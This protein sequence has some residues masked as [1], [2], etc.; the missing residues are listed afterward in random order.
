M[1]PE[2]QPEMMNATRASKEF[3]L[4]RWAALRLASRE[5]HAAALMPRGVTQERQDQPLGDDPGRGCFFRLPQDDSGN[6]R[7]KTERSRRVQLA[8]LASG[9][10]EQ[11]LRT[12]VAIR[13]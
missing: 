8:G 4:S 10:D 5:Q 1:R 9:T 7:L 11:L 3:P 6:I 13:G 12:S 2:T